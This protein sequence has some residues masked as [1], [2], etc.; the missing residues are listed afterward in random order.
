MANSLA[1]MNDKELLLK[2]T[3]L[4]VRVLAEFGLFGPEAVMPGIGFSAEDFAVRV[5]SQYLDG[6]IKVK[7][8]SYFYKAIR[9]DVI[10]KSRL[11][12]HTNTE[13]MPSNVEHD[14]ADG[15][16]TENLA[17]FPDKKPL[18]DHTLC[19]QSLSDRVRACVANDPKLKEYVEAVLD[20]GLCKP[21]EIADA[22]GV[23]VDEI[24]VRIRRL[25]RH[26][27][28]GGLKAVPHEE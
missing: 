26:L 17:E 2:L 14:D 9:N 12:A 7:S 19:V 23:P 3:A 4:A 10:D 11:L 1:D 21:A 20:L 16:P 5:F 15:E 18:I 8:L 24:Y 28:K 6:K 22:L 13:Y 27:I 25:E